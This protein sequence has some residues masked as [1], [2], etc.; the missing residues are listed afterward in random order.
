MKNTIAIFTLLISLLSAA[1]M[2]HADAGHHHDAGAS[3]LSGEPGL[4]ADVSRTVRIAMTDNM[5]FTPASVTVRQG[6]T[7]RFEVV[8]SG[9]LKHEMVLGSAAELAEHAALMRKIPEMEHA[10][11]NQVTLEPGKSATLI[12]K[13]SQAAKLEFACLEPG[14]YEAG[15]RGR[16]AV[17]AAH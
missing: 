10:D 17:I 11:A 12:W 15:M 16:V 13:F 6:E 3:A 8:N 9:Q 4:A 2:T 5:R 1:N 7:V 14:H